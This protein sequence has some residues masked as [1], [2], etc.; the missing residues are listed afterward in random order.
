MLVLLVK[1][2]NKMIVAND[3]NYSLAA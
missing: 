1:Q 3:N 2:A